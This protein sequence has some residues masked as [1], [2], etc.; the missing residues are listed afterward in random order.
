MSNHKKA[1]IALTVASIIWGAT[2]PIMKITLVTIPIF[3]L[4]LIR[5]GAASLLLLPFVANK[6][7]IS[8]EDLPTVVFSGLLGVTTN[9]GFFFWGLT[10]TTALNAGIIIASTPI[11]TLLC[12][13]IFLKEKTTI[14]L[15]IGAI[16]GLLGIAIIIGKDFVNNGF[17]LSPLGDLLILLATLAFVF[18][19]ILSKKLFKKYNSFTITFY[20]FAIGALTFLPAAILEWQKDSQWISSLST[21]PILG[22]GYGVLLS[23]FTA[24]SL[25]QWGLS[26]I[27]ASRVGFFFYIDPVVA[28]I[29]AVILLAE[30]ITIPFI[31]GSLL[32]FLGLFIAERR[33]PYFHELKGS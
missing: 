27:E 32:V 20:S 8:K 33:L 2:A 19:E 16:L 25:W 23:S 22:L 15:A 21:A 17:N 4:A 11:F 26:K 29:V 30:K 5:F 14:N 31:I 6:L 9:I 1:I 18:Y 7:S 3:S 10:L 12:A 28:T 24:Y 13:R